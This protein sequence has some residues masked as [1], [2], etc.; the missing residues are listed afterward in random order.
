MEKLRGAVQRWWEW[1]SQ[2]LQTGA[3]DDLIWDLHSALGASR[4]SV[5]Q[6]RPSVTSFCKKHFQVSYGTNTRLCLEET[7]RGQSSGVSGVTPTH[8]VLP[9]SFSESV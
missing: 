6:R 2:H 4:W 9:Q 7:A 1:T 3:Q 5:E 8:F